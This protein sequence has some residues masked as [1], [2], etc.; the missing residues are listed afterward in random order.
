MCKDFFCFVS[1]SLPSS[2]LEM[3]EIFSQRLPYIGLELI[4]GYMLCQ[5]VKTERQLIVSLLFLVL[6]AAQTK[7]NFPNNATQKLCGGLCHQWKNK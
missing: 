4:F 5:D 1:S 3:L 6:G 2:T 7:W